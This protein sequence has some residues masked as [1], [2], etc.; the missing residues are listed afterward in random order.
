MKRLSTS[1]VRLCPPFSRH[2]SV[3][4]RT[5]AGSITS[6]EEGRREECWGKATEQ[7][8]AGSTCHGVR[9]V[10]NCIA[11]IGGLRR[12]WGLRLGGCCPGHYGGVCNRPVTGFCSRR[13]AFPRVLIAFLDPVVFVSSNTTGPLRAEARDRVYIPL[14]VSLTFLCMENYP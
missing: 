11:G 10:G 13:S 3:A 9:T 1:R 4:S 2:F 12:S 6:R 5:P 14:A 8:Q 7:E